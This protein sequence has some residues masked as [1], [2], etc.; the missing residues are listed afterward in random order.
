MRPGNED[1]RTNPDDPRTR[2]LKEL[3]IAR[4]PRST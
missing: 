4:W 2:A 1:K 3:L